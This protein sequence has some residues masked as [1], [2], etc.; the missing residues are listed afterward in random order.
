MLRHVL[1]CALASVFLLAIAPSARAADLEGDVLDEI[2]FARTQPA[3]Y[4]R[5]MMRR[6]ASYGGG[7][8]GYYDNQA[9][10]DPAAFEEAVDFLM[11]QRPLSP[12]KP[13]PRLA[14]AARDHADAQA[15]SGAVGHGGRGGGPAQRL[16]RHGVWA[17]LSAEN[18]SYGYRTPREVV[19]QLIIDS[20][21]PGR[22]HRQNIFGGAYQ[23]AGVACGRHRGYGAMCVIDFA[24]AI[25]QR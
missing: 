17:G 6:P 14:A 18:I 25:V 1:P 3:A 10:Q 22:G 4:A 11:R 12:L 16:Q 23:A 7:Y 9:D 15:A 24:G 5:D 20:G 2:N 8:G 19:Q 21:V 13:D